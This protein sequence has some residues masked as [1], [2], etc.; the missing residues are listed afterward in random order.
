MNQ[1]K[2]AMNFRAPHLEC[3]NSSPL[4]LFF[5]FPTFNRRERDKWNVLLTEL[6]AGPMAD[7]LVQRERVAQDGMR[8]QAHA[9]QAAFRRRAEAQEQVETLKR[10]ADEDSQEAP[11]PPTSRPGQSSISQRKRPGGVRQGVW[12]K[13]TVRSWR[14]VTEVGLTRRDRACRRPHR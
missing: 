6:V 3:G 1:M 8:V 2:A 12:V 4:S 5:A 9:G 13:Q 14:F 10:L 11:S 7:G